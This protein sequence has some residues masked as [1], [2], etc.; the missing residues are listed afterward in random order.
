M[1]INDTQIINFPSNT[2]RR[3]SG[4]DKRKDINHKDINTRMNIKLKTILDKQKKI[5]TK[6][7]Y[8]TIKTKRFDK[9]ENEIINYF[10]K[11]KKSI[12]EKAKYNIYIIK[13][14]F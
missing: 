7:L 14:F 1:L 2:F 4:I 13:Y 6:I 12:P 10:K 11:Y 5:D 9:S 8:E 3:K